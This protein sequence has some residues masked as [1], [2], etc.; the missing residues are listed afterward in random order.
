MG[1]RGKTYSLKYIPVPALQNKHSEHLLTLLNPGC[2]RPDGGEAGAVRV[3]PDGYGVP[4][5][6]DSVLKLDVAVA[7]QLCEG[8]KTTEPYAEFKAGNSGVPGWLSGLS[9]RL[10]LRS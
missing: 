1:V 7:A 8:A 6:G 2:H 4:A 5:W 3:A 10:R 9:V